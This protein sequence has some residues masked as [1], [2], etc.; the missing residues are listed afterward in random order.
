MSEKMT[1]EKARRSLDI[2]PV[3]KITA[4]VLKRQYRRKAL[5]VHPDKNASETAADEFR[6]VREAYEYLMTANEY[7]ED[8]ADYGSGTEGYQNI[9][10]SFLTPVLNSD[11]FREIKTRVF[12]TVIEKITSKCESKAINLL[13]KLDKRAFSK[14]YEILKL[15]QDVFH[16]S[17]DFLKK[18]EESFIKK[19]QNDECIVLNPFLD[20]L[21]EN[22]LYRL[23]E[24]G[25]KYVIPL[26]HHELVYDNSGSDLYVRCVPILPE[27][28]EIDEYN[29]IHVSIKCTID[30]LWVQEYL[31]VDLGKQQ[32]N[33]PKHQI[34]MTENQTILLAGMGI[35]KINVN[36]IYDVSK[37]TD[38]YVH[39]TLLLQIGGT[40]GH[41]N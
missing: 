38:V 13:E 30:E 28:T 33:I 26:W 25:K 34:K 2:S 37:K 29:N 11:L 10:F 41:Q 20:D 18:V 35:S 31:C 6:L 14:I 1:N 12:Y 21:F 15:Y 39:L 32:I 8:D 40:A 22:N 9:L 17:D 23:V 7:M 5:Q 19:T 24:N 3:D 36:E 27:G 4:D 16:I